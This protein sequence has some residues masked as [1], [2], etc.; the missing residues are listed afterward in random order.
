MEVATYIIGLIGIVVALFPYN[1]ERQGV[2][3]W[4]GLAAAVYGTFVFIKSR[5]SPAIFELLFH[6]RAPLLVIINRA[7]QETGIS[8]NILMDTAEALART[9][10]ITLFGELGSAKRSTPIPK[11]HFR[12]YTMYENPMTGSINTYDPKI[13]IADQDTDPCYFKLRAPTKVLP[14]LVSAGKK[15]G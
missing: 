2:A 15:A 6:R 12:L 7:S 14:I 8:K 9:G 11:E 10:R 3:F 4:I 1:I 5:V 13:P